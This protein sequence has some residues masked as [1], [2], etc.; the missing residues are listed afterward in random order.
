[1]ILNTISHMGRIESY[2]KVQLSNGRLFTQRIK[3]SK[4]RRR[5]LAERVRPSRAKGG[6]SILTKVR[7][8]HDPPKRL[9]SRYLAV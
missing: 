8:C 1:M 9:L 4:N 6:G 7:D 3:A 5:T 2:A